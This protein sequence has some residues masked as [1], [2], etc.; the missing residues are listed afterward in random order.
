[1]DPLFFVEGTWI[2][3]GLTSGGLSGSGLLYF[4]VAVVC[5]GDR[6][7]HYTCDVAEER[8][9]VFSSGGESQVPWGLVST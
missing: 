8:V 6:T 4:G 5:D 1:M 3:L 9:R 2:P 7:L